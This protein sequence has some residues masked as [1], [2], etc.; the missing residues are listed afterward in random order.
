MISFAAPL[1]TLEHRPVPQPLEGV[2]NW[3]HPQLFEALE[4]HAGLVI[5][6]GLPEHFPVSVPDLIFEQ[7]GTRFNRENFG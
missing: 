1:I 4:V 2:K 3:P 7:P 6:P 5:F